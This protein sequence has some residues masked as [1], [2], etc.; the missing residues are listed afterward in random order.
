[1]KHA[2]A[3]L[4]V[5]AA[6]AGLAAS[7]QQSPPATPD[8]K[9]ATMSED[10]RVK[11][12]DIDSVMSKDDTILLDV[13]EPK[14]IEE[15]GG[16]EGAINIPI[17]QLENRLGELPKDKTILT[18]CNSGGRAGRA[19]A[20]LEKNGFKVAGFCGLKGYKGTKATPAKKTGA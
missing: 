5:V 20:L 18:A 19:A 9:A 17:T 14:E 10:K 8:Q 11:M 6:V 1:M 4:L 2:F 7:Q 12:E 16:Y 15:L 3:A 13:R